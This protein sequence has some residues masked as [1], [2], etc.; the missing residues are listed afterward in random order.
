V[1][2]KLNA[3]QLKKLKSAIVVSGSDLH[4]VLEHMANELICAEV[5]KETILASIE[6]TAQRALWCA[7]TDAAA[8]LG[9]ELPDYAAETGPA[10]ELIDAAAKKFALQLYESVLVEDPDAV[11]V[12]THGLRV[13]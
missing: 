4:Y 6:I 11:N 9:I 13:V 2:T 12:S 7:A 1:Q 5:R 3:G 10:R 8:G